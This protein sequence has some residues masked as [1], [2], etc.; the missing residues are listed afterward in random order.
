MYRFTSA[1]IAAASLVFACSSAFAGAPIEAKLDITDMAY[2]LTSLS[3]GKASSVSF[4]PGN[5]ADFI[6]GNSATLAQGGTSA[7]FAS[8]IFTADQNTMT[9]HNP[10]AVSGVPFPTGSIQLDSADGI[11]HISTG[12]GSISVSTSLSNKDQMISAWSDARQNPTTRVAAV[13]MT[14]EVPYEGGGTGGFPLSGLSKADVWLVTV[15]PRTTLSITGKMTGTTT[16]D[17]FAAASQGL[18]DAASTLGKNLGGTVFWNLDLGYGD[19]EH[20]NT[21]LDSNGYSGY[22]SFN[23]PEGYQ[24]ARTEGPYDGRLELDL[25]NTS[26]TSHTYWLRF[27]AVSGLYTTLGVDVVPEPGTRSFMG[28]G[29]LALCALSKRRRAGAA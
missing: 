28:L 19:A 4:T 2:S 26:N 16:V 1:A 3:G 25:S 14:P 10:L 22:L 9:A 23:Y 5:L 7:Y 8:G 11:Q 6:A 13:S 15:S 12:P 29:L 20:G 27:A 21:E 18:A 24:Y 17:T